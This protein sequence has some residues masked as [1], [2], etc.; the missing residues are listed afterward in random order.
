MR[1]QKQLI[2]HTIPHIF[3]RGGFGLP[4]HGVLHSHPHLTLDT[5]E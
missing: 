2:L 1:D 5:L 3:D 4:L